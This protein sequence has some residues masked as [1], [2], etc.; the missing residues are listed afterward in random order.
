M[1]IKINRDYKEFII[2]ICVTLG[3]Y[4]WITIIWQ[5]L[6]VTFDGWIQPSKTDSIIGFI[7]TVLLWRLIRKWYVEKEDYK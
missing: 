2:D 3:I 7:I 5:I 4:Q 1:K 6:E